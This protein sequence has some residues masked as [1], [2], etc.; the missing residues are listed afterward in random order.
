[1]RWEPP[2]GLARLGRRERLDGDNPWGAPVSDRVWT[3]QLSSQFQDLAAAWAQS[4]AWE[5]E[6]D[7]GGQKMPA[8]MIGDMVLAEVVLHGWDLARATDQRL[9]VSGDV[10]AELW[11]GVEAT[12]EM[13]RKMGAYGDAVTVAEDATDLDRA[14]GAAG[15]NP[16][17]RA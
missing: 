12:A 10:A 6:V 2:A 8:S 13:G 17:W 9:Q 16:S 5:G 15:R 4:S 3:D 11:R 1:M 7:M 14:L